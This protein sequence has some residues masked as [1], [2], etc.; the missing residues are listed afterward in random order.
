MPAYNLLSHV[1]LYYIGVYVS[2]RELSI[3]NNCVPHVTNIDKTVQ[4]QSNPT[5]LSLTYQ[6]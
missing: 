3:R 2:R 4:I 6:G 5:S 1:I